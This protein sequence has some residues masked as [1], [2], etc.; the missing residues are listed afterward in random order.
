M[1][2]PTDA[3]LVVSARADDTEA[4]R[5][6]LERYQT[7]AFAIAQ[8][9]VTQIETA[10][11]L[12]QEAMLQAYLSL[13]QLRDVTRFKSWFYGIVLNVCRY[14]QRRQQSPMLS[15]NMWREDL[16]TI[17]SV[18][19]SDIAEESEL[20]C[21]IQEAIR[22]LSARTRV[23][24]LLFYYED[25][26]VEEIARRLN[27]SPV[28]V[29]SRLYQGRNQLQQQ[30]TRIYPEFLPRLTR[31]QRR[32]V[33]ANVRMNVVKVVP[34]AQWLL[35]MLCDQSNQRVLPLWLHP[36]EGLALAALQ[37]VLKVPTPSVSLDPSGYLDFVSDMLQETGTTLQA[38]RI[39]E[40]QERLFYAR[41]VLQSAN[42]NREIKARV[43]VGLT[44]ATRAGS[45]ITIEDVV[46][47]QQG[48]DL[49]TAEGQTLEQRLDNVVNSVIAKFRPA[50]SPKL[51]RI[52][53]PTNMQF[54]E[55]LERWELRGSFFH[56][57]SGLHWRD[58]NGGTDQVGPQPGVMSGYLKAQVP[59]P[60]GFADLRQ[61]ILAQHYRGKRVRLAADVKIVDVEQQAGLYLRVIDQAM[62][63]PPEEREQVTFS[64]TQ[65]WTRYETQIGVPIDSKDILFGISLTGKGQV[66]VTNVQLEIVEQIEE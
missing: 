2:V 62:S 26:S 16:P 3:D 63:R 11:D 50:A 23:V 19:P 7:M 28:A 49:S 1:R 33:M 30:L 29:K 52:A 21:A 59:E 60:Q 57:P 64:G 17:E 20:R 4:F 14:W 5:L 66:W 35:A 27:L 6:L 47:E 44:L 61:A 36:M 18:D 9:K 25:L 32:K 53:E 13:D 48:M 8:H 34:T 12:V 65:D 37:G 42:G 10:E 22:M 45:P 46:L 15:L 39:E 24:M 58:Y 31:K 40:L 41:V 56:D 55:G 54:T 38:V 51:P 43:G